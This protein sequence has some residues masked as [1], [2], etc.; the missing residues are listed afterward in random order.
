MELSGIVVGG[1]GKAAGFVG[2]RGYSV[3]IRRSLE[4]DL[5]SGTLNLQVDPEEK[6]AFLAQVR[7]F[8]LTGFTEDGVEF[9]DLTV[10]PVVFSDGSR[11]G[12]VVPEKTR[13]PSDIIEIVAAVN[14][15]KR[16]ALSDGSVF[17][18]FPGEYVYPQKQ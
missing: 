2:K 7:G 15:R 14:L 8:D 9:G 10:Y 6:E 3:Q 11:G 12:I 4:I 13:H 5:F 16:F 17:T 1:E 18:V